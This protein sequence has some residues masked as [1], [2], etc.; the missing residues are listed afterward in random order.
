MKQLTHGEVGKYFY[1][2]KEDILKNTKDYIFG[3]HPVLEAL[4]AG[5]EMNKILFRKGIRTDSIATLFQFVRQYN[6]P[7]QLKN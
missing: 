6:I 3:I 1:R 5:R 2:I 4:K 7:F